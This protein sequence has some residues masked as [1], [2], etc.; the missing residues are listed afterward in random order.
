[1]LLIEL[2]G[3]RE[4]ADSGLQIAAGNSTIKGLVMNRWSGQAILVR[5]K[6]GNVI[7]GN[8]LGM[9]PS[10]LIARPNQNGIV[11]EA[12]N[13]GGNTIGGLTPADRNIISGNSNHGIISDNDGTAGNTI[14]GN[15]FMQNVVAYETASS[16]DHVGGPT[17]AARNLFAAN[18]S[19][20]LLA[21]TGSANV[22]IQGNYIGTDLSGAAAM[23]NG[24]ISGG[25]GIISRGTKIT[26]GGTAPGA[27]NL[28]SG[29]IG[30]GITI[31]PKGGDVKVD[32][33]T[34]EVKPGA[35]VKD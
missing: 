10:A 2:S 17:L 8:V 23:G 18:T 35:E 7:S 29:N 22:I 16:G 32:T 33:K 1:M 4:F 15:F 11:L 13:P 3:E 28:I 30:N 5:D 9:D 20:G 26:I 34:I 6:G 31:E 14:V 21:E 24:Q 19:I 27:G 25:G 12:S